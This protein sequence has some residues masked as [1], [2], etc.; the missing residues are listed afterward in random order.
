MSRF[1]LSLPLFLPLVVTLL[2]APVSQAAEISEQHAE[3]T[4]VPGQI[5][6]KPLP[7]VSDTE[8]LD[9]IDFYSA[10]LK[11]YLDPI[12]TR[13][14]RI[15]EG[16][17]QAIIQELREDPLIEFVEQDKAVPVE[18]I[19][20]NDPRYPDQWHLP[21]TNTPDAWG[22]AWGSGVIV[23]ILDTG[24]D[25]DHPDLVNQFAP[26]GYNVADNNSDFDDI[27]G[28]GTRVAGIVAAQM[29]NGV[30]VASFAP[31]AKILPVKVTM[32]ADSAAYLSDI[33]DGI[34][35]AMA[36]GA[37]IVNAS[38]RVSAS[39]TVQAAA[40]QFHDA[41]GLT[42]IAAGNDSEQISTANVPEIITVSATDANDLL[43]SFSNY[44]NIID[45]SAPGNAVL[46]TSNA[47]GYKYSTGTSFAAPSTAGVLALIWS[48]DVSLTNTE[49]ETIL[50]QTA[51]DLG[52]AGWDPQYGEGRV[53]AAAAVTAAAATLEPD[54]TPPV[55]TPPADLSQEATGP[56]T[57]VDLGAASAQDNVDGEL[58][59]TPDTAGPFTVGVHTVTWSAIDAAGNTGTAT[60]QVTITDTTAPTVTAPPDQTVQYLGS[61][62]SVDL[63]SAEAEDLV[64]GLVGAAA[65]DTGPFDVGVHTVTWSAQDSAG[66]LGTDTQTVT[67]TTSDITAPVVT[68]PADI[69]IEAT[70]ELTSVSLG[71]ASATDE[72]D[73]NLTPKADETGPFA[74]GTHAV[75]WS[76]TDSAGNTGVA[77]QQVTVTDTTAPT[78]PS[79]PEITTPSTGHLTPVALGE[80]AAPDMVD[81]NVSMVADKIGPFKSGAHTIVWTATDSAGNTA[82]QAQTLNVLPRVYVARTQTAE[83]GQP[84][85]QLVT[86]SGEAPSY[87]VEI[88]Y[89]VSGSLVAGQDHDLV[90]G[91]ITVHSGLMGML[92][93][94]ITPVAIEGDIRITLES[95]QNAVLSKA[96]THIV[97]VSHGN[98][99]PQVNIT[100][101]QN[102]VETSSIYPDAGPVTVNAAV[103]D[104]N[105]LDTHTYTWGAVESDMLSVSEETSSSF[106]F[107]P[108]HLSAGARTLTL[109]VADSGIPA[110]TTEVE[111]SFRV[112]GKTFPI[113]KMEDDSD[114][115]GLSDAMEGNGDMLDN[116]I[117]NYLDSMD[118]RHLLPTRAHQ[119]PASLM[120]AEAGARLRLGRIAMD[121]GHHASAVT[122][123]DVTAATHM[124]AE[125]DYT[126]PDGL[127]DFEIMG[128][129]SELPSI[130]LVIP[131]SKPIPANAVYRKYSAANGWQDFVVDEHNTIAS[132]PSV[133]G[134][135]PGPGDASYQ[136]GLVAGANCLELTLE[137]GGAND[138]DGRVNGHI[139]DPSGIA[140]PVETEDDDDTVTT[141]DPGD[142]GGSD[143]GGGGCTLRPAATGAQDMSWV[144][145]LAG[146]AGLGW[147][148]RG[149]H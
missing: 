50:K 26:G 142:T 102:G 2:A 14:L 139:V 80:Y 1:S 61:P 78:A 85:M 22:T 54:T 137:D 100:F 74:V 96:D 52:A 27:D 53:D 8:F 138:E 16:Y 15:P 126:Y 107:D 68:P 59:P 131:L 55:V 94:N 122:L 98:V 69:V 119:S 112:M 38:F 34:L 77:T 114:G 33:A 79:I 57:E 70:S 118:A 36:N 104:P 111:K 132:A 9:L 93:F 92:T 143:G 23:G 141:P 10:D 65:S 95:P 110:K 89:T 75:T 73:G 6:V 41:G 17:E 108:A 56:T 91:V 45:I 25:I 48:V 72:T 144:L 146:L 134:A 128:M 88:P 123:E 101:H 46:S 4:T 29:H 31:E 24:V 129:G 13:V 136:S 44:G 51:H 87:P 140:V 135:C 130:S 62:V 121:K 145:V 90:D 125:T 115:D 37:S 76:A 18:A 58:T 71:G 105:G 116:G 40:R 30:G 32:G 109:K 3:V 11:K 124:P 67:V 86:L 63:G 12:N 20:P 106:T 60:Q 66:N 127:Y 149:A 47:G 19:T 120:E 97:T 82:T 117:P 39:P 43:A 83:P 49:V 7:D 81:G 103:I 64:D 21:L 113:L 148:R 99:P 133:D 84:V 28:H 35:H 147:H 42:V 5:I